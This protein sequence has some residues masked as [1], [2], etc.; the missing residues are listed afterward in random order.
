MKKI[1]MYLTVFSSLFMASC[2]SDD[3][4][5][6][7]DKKQAIV[8]FLKNGNA[9]YWKQI[10]SAIKE[11]CQSMNCEPLIYSVKD[12]SDLDA[13]LEEVSR[14]AELK[15]TYD[16]KGVIIAPI[17]SDANHKVEEALAN[18]VGDQIPVIIID[19]PVD[20]KNSP[21]KEA[22]KAYVGTDNRAAGQS[23]AETVDAKGSSI[24]TARVK[25]SIPALARYEGFCDGIGEELPVWETPR[26]EDTPESMTEQLAQYPDAQ[27]IVFFNG[28]L[29]A[30]VLE[31]CKGKNVY[32]FDAYKP[33]FED[34]LNED[35]CMK[36][37]IAQNTFQMGKQA[38][39]ALTD[40]A[41]KGNIFIPTIYI[42]RKT[43]FTDLKSILPFLEYFGIDISSEIPD[44][45]IGKSDC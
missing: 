34:L 35:G 40:P 44:D 29:C 11:E 4:E 8:S 3:D 14:L 38:V 1:F 18:L 23:L 16:I 45:G 24:L 17:Y 25:E 26:D 6:V 32:S 21:L 42:S 36:G 5:N 20:E 2:S 15:K 30:S 12:D 31:A 7:S 39:Q 9:D 13:Q 22:I 43:I 19:S 33:L 10:E 28:L 37:I 27:N 41:A